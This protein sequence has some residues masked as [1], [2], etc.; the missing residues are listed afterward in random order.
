[1]T[2]SWRRFVKKGGV[3]SMPTAVRCEK[4]VCNAS[5]SG[6][7]NLTAQL[8]VDLS[9]SFVSRRQSVWC[10]HSSA[11]GLRLEWLRGCDSGCSERNEFQGLR[12]A[13]PQNLV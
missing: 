12:V 11:M 4:R 8:E 10:G 2:S 1:M 7:R 5:R 9:I 13:R 6:K 3:A